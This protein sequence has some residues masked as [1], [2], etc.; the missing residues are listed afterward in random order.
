[1]LVQKTV[2]LKIM[3]RLID[4]AVVHFHHI[5]QSHDILSLAMSYSSSPKAFPNDRVSFSRTLH[6]TNRAH[7]VQ[8]RYGSIESRPPYL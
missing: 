3:T 8:K 2:I 5:F 1:M 4:P 7:R 6:H